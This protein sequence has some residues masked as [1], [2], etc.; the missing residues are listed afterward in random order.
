MQLIV[1]ALLV[2]VCS[3]IPPVPK[4][5]ETFCASGEVEYHAAESTEIGE[6]KLA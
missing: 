2:A 5:P 1:I 4:I 6:C 3:A